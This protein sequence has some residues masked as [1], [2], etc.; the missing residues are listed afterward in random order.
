MRR[1]QEEHQGGQLGGYCSNPGGRLDCGWGE[2]LGLAGAGGHDENGQIWYLL[3][4]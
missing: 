1:G 2:L 4:R 3:E